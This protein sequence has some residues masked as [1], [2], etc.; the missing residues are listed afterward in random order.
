MFAQA[1]WIWPS[2]QF[3]KNQR[4]NFLFST[5]ISEI[6]GPVTAN[7]G[8]ETKYRLFVND[9]L[10]I[11]DGGL[12]RESLPGCGYYDVVDITKHL[13]V[14][15]NE[16]KI[17][18]WYYGNGGRNNTS[19]S[20]AGLIFSCDKLSLCSDEKTACEI[21][22]AYKTPS[23]KEPTF[24]Y[25]G[26]HTAYDATVHPFSLS[27]AIRPDAGSA[28]ILGAYGDQPWGNLQER[29]IPHLFFSERI[30][31]KAE[32]SDTTYTV[33]L[34]YAMHF[35]PYFKVNGTKGSV[36]EVHSGISL[37]YAVMAKMQA[38]NAIITATKRIFLFIRFLLLVILLTCLYKYNIRIYYSSIRTINK[39]PP[40]IF[41]LFAQKYPTRPFGRVGMASPKVYGINALHCM[42]SLVELIPCRLHGLHS[43]LA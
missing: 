43:R 34:P 5:D 20:S 16:I 9:A 38:S 42:L 11:F 15:H 12:F 37:A 35:S 39:S 28:V 24:L 21:D 8:C 1:K 7:I 27:P 26:N 4:A 30:V 32:K 23:K 31:C 13:R 18:V 17:Q 41:V 29:S 3:E 6:N 2:N 10:V 40:P 14:G 22:T 19:C 25:G 33:T 36:I